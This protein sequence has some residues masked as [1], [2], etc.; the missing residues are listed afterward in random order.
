[1]KQ[2]VRLCLLRRYIPE[3]RT[4]HNYRC[5]NLKFY[6]LSV[7]ILHYRLLKEQP[8]PDME[9]LKIHAKDRVML[10]SIRALLV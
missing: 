3:D 2:A 5:E 10:E 4:Y 1:M 9:L 7:F 8:A 6:T